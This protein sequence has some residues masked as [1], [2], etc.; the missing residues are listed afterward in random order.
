MFAVFE[1][2][3]KESSIGEKDESNPE[4]E[5][6]MPFPTPGCKLF[7]VIKGLIFRADAA[8][9]VSGAKEFS[10]PPG[11]EACPRVLGGPPCGSNASEKSTANR[12]MSV[13]SCGCGDIECC[14]EVFDGAGE[15]V[16]CIGEFP[17]LLGENV[18]L[19]DDLIF[20]GGPEAEAA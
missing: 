17:A 1:L 2:D 9:V 11:D 8:A 4:D 13:T 20:A 12:L 15:N 19:G 18:I 6:L 5:V 16:G 14:R 7:D 3:S 10:N